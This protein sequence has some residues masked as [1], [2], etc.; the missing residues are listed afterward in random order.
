MEQ[1]ANILYIFIVNMCISSIRIRGKTVI[2]RYIIIIIII[3]T[4]FTAHICQTYVCGD[5]FE[6]PRM[7]PGDEGADVNDGK[8]SSRPYYV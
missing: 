2:S 3:M 6:W 5:Y 7:K 4:L 8:C 1:S